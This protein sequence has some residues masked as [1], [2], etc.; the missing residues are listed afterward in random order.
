MSSEYHGRLR[1]NAQK[2]KKFRCETQDNWL[3][4]RQPQR[5]RESLLRTLLRSPN[6]L[7]GSERH[8][9]PPWHVCAPPGQ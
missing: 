5:E 7:G 3:S 8:P 4:R 6:C 9:C 2:A 1:R